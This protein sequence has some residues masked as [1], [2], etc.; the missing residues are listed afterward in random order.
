MPEFYFN[1]YL[2]KAGKIQRGIYLA[3]G[4]LTL[5]TQNKNLEVKSKFTTISH[6]AQDQRNLNRYYKDVD[7]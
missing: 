2:R 3:Q 4:H 6:C 7:P 1:C 5:K